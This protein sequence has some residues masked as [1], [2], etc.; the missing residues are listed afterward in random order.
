VEFLNKPFTMEAL[1]RA[2]ARAAGTAGPEQPIA[3][4]PGLGNA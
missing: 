3:V 1:A 4:G 2:V